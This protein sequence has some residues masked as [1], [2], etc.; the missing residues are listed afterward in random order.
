MSWFSADKR[1]F[2]NC[3]CV[4][5][6]LYTYNTTSFMHYLVT[7]SV[8]DTRRNNKISIYISFSLKEILNETANSKSY[9]QTVCSTVDSNQSRTFR[10]CM[11]VGDCVFINKLM[12]TSSKNLKHRIFSSE[13]F[14]TLDC[15]IINVRYMIIRYIR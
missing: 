11:V 5:T 15:Y 9:A 7:H 14:F 2:F 1:I 3:S 8:R 6:S 12:K 4:I 13:Y 10:Q